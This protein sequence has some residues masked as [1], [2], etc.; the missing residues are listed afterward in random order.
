MTIKERPIL[1][2]APM[3]RA[4]LDGRK[5]QTRRICKVAERHALSFVVDADKTGYFGD[6]E[7]EVVFP[8]PYGKIGDRLWVRETWHTIFDNELFD[9]EKFG[10]QK[11]AC[12]ADNQGFMPVCKDG[13]VYRADVPNLI[14]ARWT[15]SIYMPRWASRILLEVT[16]VRVERLQD[17]SE[18]DAKAEGVQITDEY[19]GCADDIDS[20]AHAYKFLWD[21]TN[22]KGSWDL[23]PFVWVIEF[24]R[25]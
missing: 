17:I 4:I 21:S 25:I 10:K 19:T 6:E 1:F 3:V 9:G 16:N 5:S 13:I 8:C 11:S 22:G 24:R 2:S 14:G 15:P 18:E 23:N 7:G 20:H 12:I